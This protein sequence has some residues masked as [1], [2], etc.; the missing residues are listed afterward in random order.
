MTTESTAGW[1]LCRTE[2]GGGT[3]NWNALKLPWEA[4]ERAAESWR[5][6]I[7]GV[8]KPWLCWNMNDNWCLVQQKLI[9]EIG[10]TPIVGWDPNCGHSPSRLAPGAMAIDF[11]QQLEFPLLFP[12]VPIELAFLWADKLAFWHADLL[13]TR[14]KMQAAGKLF[15]SLNQNEMAAV[16][17]YGGFRNLLKLRKHRYW[18]VLGCVTRGASLDNFNTGCGWWR[19]WASHI[20]KPADTTEQSRRKRYYNDHGSG[21]MYWKRH[22]SG[23]VK[24]IRESFIDEGHFSITNKKNYIRGS[25]KSEEMDLNFNLTDIAARFGFSDLLGPSS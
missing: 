2:G 4:L 6:E 5:K 22:Q 3:G 18:E 13:L 14:P 19:Q 25:N 12:H 23:R 9:L 11:N 8:A 10:W 15:E 7:S 1:D 21:I 17:S 16:Y 20:N 24:S